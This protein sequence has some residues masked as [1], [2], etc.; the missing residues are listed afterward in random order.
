MAS[1]RIWCARTGRTKSPRFGDFGGIRQWV[2]SVFDTLRGQLGLERHGARTLEGVMA[3]VASKLLAMAAGIW[4]S[5]K[6]NA[7]R[8]RSLVAYDH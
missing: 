1:G 4:H 6:V 5:W 2:E 7:P 8:K 3:R